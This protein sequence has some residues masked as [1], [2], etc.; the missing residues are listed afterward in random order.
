MAAGAVESV[1]AAEPPPAPVLP[2]RFDAETVSITIAGDSAQFS[3]EYRFVRSRPD[4]AGTAIL[5]PYPVEPRLGGARTLSLE[6]RVP[7]GEWRAIPHEEM[8]EL[9]GCA[10]ELPADPGGILE[11][12]AIYRQALLARYARYIVSTTNRWGHGLSRARFEVHLE[13]GERLRR[14]NFPFRM[15]SA[16]G[17][18][19]YCYEARD[20]LPNRDIEL[21]W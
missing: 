13:R 16:R 8:P 14:V 12:R 20:F 9:T 4:S 5:F 19:F 10:W 11:V 17:Q 7:G 3:G 21:E 15:V 2:L 1:R 18:S 6:A